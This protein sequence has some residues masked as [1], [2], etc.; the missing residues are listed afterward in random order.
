[1]CRKLGEVGFSLYASPKYLAKAGTP[2]R[3][4]GLAGH[5]LIRFMG[6]PPL[7]GPPFMG[8]SIEGARVSI[9]TNDHAIQV[10]AAASDLG[11]ADLP[12]YLGD[13]CRDLVR[14]WPDE[15]PPSRSLWLI[16]HEDLRRAARV[17]IV[18]TAITDAI[19]RD[20]R[21]LRWGPAGKPR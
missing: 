19:E 1:V 15:R 16:M 3:H 12:C 11:I 17:R 4:G 10:R 20:A 8:E 18:A 7:M 5:N 21:L 13:G 14:L 9:R 6:T 2:K